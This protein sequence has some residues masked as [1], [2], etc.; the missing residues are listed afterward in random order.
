MV[1]LIISELIGFVDESDN[2]TSDNFIYLTREYGAYIIED[3]Y[4]RPQRISADLAREEIEKY[5]CFPEDLINKF[6]L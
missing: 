4:S 2:G 6:G 1:Q 3:S 5:N